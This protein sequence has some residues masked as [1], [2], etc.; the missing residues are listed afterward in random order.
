MASYGASLAASDAQATA[1]QSNQISPTIFNFGSGSATGGLYELEGG[2][3][4]PEAR[5]EATA[6]VA[7][8][9][10]GMMAG[11]VDR[12]K[13]GDAAS[14]A[15]VVVGAYLLYKHLRG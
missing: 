15:L 7:Q 9:Q 2:D 10:P 14:W 8:G 12:L 5:A 1:H 3:Q 13:N 6:S 11:F 4:E